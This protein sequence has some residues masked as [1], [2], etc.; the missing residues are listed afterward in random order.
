MLG[1]VQ[2]SSLLARIWLLNRPLRV[3]NRRLGTDSLRPQR[4]GDVYYRKPW[5][6]GCDRVE[7]S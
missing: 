7:A 6:V 1:V 2:V 4:G 3:S 5:A